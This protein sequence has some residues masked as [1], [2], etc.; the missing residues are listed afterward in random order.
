M[1]EPESSTSSRSWDTYWAGTGTSGAFSSGGVTHP[2]VD[3][4]WN[5]LF[6]EYDGRDGGYALL[7]VAT[8]NGAVV[9]RALSGSASDAV[10][11]TCVDI[12][13]S[14]INNVR[15][16]FPEITGIVADAREIPLDDAGFD[17][18]AS[19][20]GA[21]YAGAPAI[22]EAAR[23]VA[24][25]GRIAMLLHIDT[26]SIHEECR[27]SLAAVTALQEARFVPLARSFFEAGFNAVRGGDRAAYDDAGRKLSPAVEAAERI[28]AT[29]GEGVAG[30]TVAKLYA[31][32]G[33]IHERIQYFDADEVLQWIT[34]M[35]A[36]LVAYGERM[37]SMM[38]AA[39]D[40]PAFD[41]ITGQLTQDGFELQRAE[42]LVPAGEQLPVAWALVGT[43]SA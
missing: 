27:N 11:I 12:S 30:G 20:F 28:I 25:G 2:A 37:S 42:A 16:R 1:N 18:V 7:D 21:E 19:Q 26:G 34:A 23:L 8:G 6:V 43:R 15:A 10:R 9:E 29:Y 35:E 14:A 17:L 13:E 36:E 31:D 5:A 40:R 33:H 38:G 24:P 39:L 3:A 4:F 41:R 32:V 22:H